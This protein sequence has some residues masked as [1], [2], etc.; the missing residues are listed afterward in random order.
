MSYIGWL[1]LFWLF[2]NNFH[3]IIISWTVGNVRLLRTVEPVWSSPSA[4]GKHRTD[5]DPR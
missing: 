4:A 2:C 1:T 3:L 5:H